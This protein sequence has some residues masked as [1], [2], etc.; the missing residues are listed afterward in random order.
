VYAPELNLF[1][2]IKATTSNNM[3]KSTDGINW[4]YLSD[5]PTFSLNDI[6]WSP[7]LSIFVVVYEPTGT[8]D[9]GNSTSIST[10]SDTTT[11]T[12]RTNPTYQ[13]T[14]TF[15]NGVTSTATVAYYAD[16]PQCI[17]WS[18]ELNLFVIIDEIGYISTSSNGTSWTKRARPNGNVTGTSVCW[19]PELSI[20]VALFDNGNV[21]YS[22]NGINWFNVS[23]TS[24]SWND[25]IWSPQLGLFVA[26]ADSGTGN[27]VM[28]SP[29]G[30][31]WT[32]GS[33]SDYLWN[34]IVWSDLG[35][36]LGIARWF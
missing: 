25:V 15:P 10:S 23:V 36:F 8:P 1:V 33:I 5:S 17:T 11:W 3:M 7:E 9:F 27:R 24:N 14:F 19:S 30:T 13:D 32:D 21:S 6:V 20:L 4:S 22:S 16:K 31:T 29:D 34:G 35:Y 26:V 2:A 28:T 12:A 18:P